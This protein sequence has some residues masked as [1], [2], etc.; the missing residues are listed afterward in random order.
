MQIVIAM[1]LDP[2]PLPIRADSNQL[3]Q[4][5]LNL[6]VNARD[7]MPGGGAIRIETVRESGD[8]LRARVPEAAAAGYACLRITDEGMGMDDTTRSRMFEPFFTTKPAGQG[9]GLG[10]AVVHGIV[11]SHRGFIEVRSERGTGTTVQVSFPTAEPEESRETP[12][13][14]RLSKTT[15]TET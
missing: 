14:M 13:A 3:H 1:N 6:A 9:E 11:K 8:E 10:L 12:P 5:L 2:E 15:G 4:A 7:A